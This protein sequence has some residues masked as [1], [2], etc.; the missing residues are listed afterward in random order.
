[1]TLN[2]PTPDVANQSV[3]RLREKFSIDLED[4]QSVTSGHSRKGMTFR[5]S[6]HGFKGGHFVRNLFDKFS[7]SFRMN[8]PI[9]IYKCLI[10]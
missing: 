6:T 2:S 5:I 3:S 10:P 1:M 9:R 8:T 7:C 4:H